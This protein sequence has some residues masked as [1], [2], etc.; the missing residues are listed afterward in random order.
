MSIR[1]AGT[2]AAPFDDFRDLVKSLPAPDAEALAAARARQGRLTKPPGSLGRLEQ[3]AIWLAGWQGQEK[4][5]IERPMVAV[6]AGNHGVAA[7]GVAPYPADVTQQMVA[8]FRAGG[9]SIN[10][11]CTS[12]NVGLKVFELALELPTGDIAE[13]DALSERDCA[14]TIAYGME[15]IEG[16]D[17]LCLG[18]MGVGNTTVASALFCALFGGEP[19]EWVGYGSG[20]TGAVLEAKIEAV[21]LACERVRG[22]TDPLVILKR[23]GGRELA[24]MVG[25]VLAARMQRIPVVV[26]GFVTSAAVAVVHKMAPGATDHCIFAHRSAEKA[27]RQ[28]VEAMGG[29]PLLDLGM[30]LGE[31]TGAAIAAAIVRAAAYTHSNMATFGE[32]GVS[33]EGVNVDRAGG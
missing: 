30:R 26:D 20:S 13:K 7:R 33:G 27:H 6:F 2:R 28:A 24:A 1:D 4:P 12:F 14:A 22:E 10:Q 25:A 5:V 19:E 8:N 3:I 23:V 18:E 29:A 31:G 21:R 15:A 11:L 32:A 17:L 16:I 9:A